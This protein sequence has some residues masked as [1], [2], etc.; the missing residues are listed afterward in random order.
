V[1][2]TVARLVSAT[3]LLTVTDTVV[4]GGRVTRGVACNG[5]DGVRAVG[6]EASVPAKRKAKRFFGTE[7]GAVEFELQANDADVVDAVAVIATARP[8]TFAPLAGAGDG[9]GRRGGCRRRR[10]SRS[11]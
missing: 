5:G 9:N 11:R 10:C 4:A 3:T 8:E 1:I 2:E 6:H 7:I